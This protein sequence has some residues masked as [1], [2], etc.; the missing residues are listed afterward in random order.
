VKINRPREA[1]YLV[2]GFTEIVPER[3]LESGPDQ[4]FAATV[5]V[6]SKFVIK[7]GQV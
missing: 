1:G 4:A 5:N 3:C 2:F 6:V 7:V